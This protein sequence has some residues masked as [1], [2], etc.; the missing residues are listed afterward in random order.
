VNDRIDDRASLSQSRPLTE[1][2]LE[3]VRPCA[4][5][6]SLSYRDD[7]DPKGLPDRESGTDGSMEMSPPTGQWIKLLTS[8]VISVHF[9]R[10]I[11]KAESTWSSYPGR[12]SQWPSGTARGQSHP[13][14]AR[15]TPESASGSDGITGTTLLVVPRVHG[16]L[17]LLSSPSPS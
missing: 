6:S 13:N 17:T 12:H 3:V 4:D 16:C 2:Y 14:S 5:D 7:K 1:S 11:K 8:T 15:R 9:F 10:I